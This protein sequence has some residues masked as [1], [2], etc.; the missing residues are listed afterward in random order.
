[1]FN[2]LNKVFKLPT[3]IVEGAKIYKFPF[4]NGQEIAVS[5][6]IV[7]TWI[8][9]IALLIILSFG[10]RNLELI[11]SKKQ[12]VFESIYD[13]YNWL[14][15]NVLK[16]WNTKF[17]AYISALMT[18]L[19]FSNTISLIPLPSFSVVDGVLHVDAFFSAPTSD[20]N[21]TVALATITTIAFLFYGIK[22]NGFGGYIKGLMSPNIV[23]FPLNIIGEMA[24]PLN[25]SMRLFGNILGGGV[26][27]TLIYQFTSWIFSKT[28]IPVP[29][30]IAPLH[31]YF[32]LFSGLIQ[33]FVFTMLTLVYVSMA[34]GDNEPEPV[35]N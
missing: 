9:M 19:I 21:T 31:L 8:I 33:S 24:K 4:I 14:T 16:N 6:T 10:T 12:V 13:F 32:D 25:I 22:L 2:F 20:L 15:T 18:Y 27:M 23:M 28:L 29:L 11:P 30:L 17:I 34:I 3:E 1:M 7:I 5:E 35:I 26:I